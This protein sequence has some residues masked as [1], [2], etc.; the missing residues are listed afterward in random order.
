MLWWYRGW[1]PDRAAVST[2]G[3]EWRPPSFQTPGPAQLSCAGPAQHRLEGDG[4]FA[5]AGEAR[6]LPDKDLLEGCV[7]GARLVE[8]HAKLRSIG[9]APGLSLVDIL[10]HDKVA[11]LLGMVAQRP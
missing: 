2:P 3:S 11:V 7:V 5:L 9:D 6:E 4:V 8:H 10:A 1:G